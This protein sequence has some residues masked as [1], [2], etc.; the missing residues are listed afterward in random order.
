[1]GFGR[2]MP[3]DWNAIAAEADEAIRSVADIS[4]AGGYPAALLIPAN[5]P[6]AS[7]GGPPTGSD[8]YATVYCIEG[9]REIRDQ[10]GMTVLEVRRTLTISATGAVP[11]KGQSVAVGVTAE[12][13][14]A[15]DS[16]WHEIVE[17]RPTSPAGVAVLFEVD[18]AA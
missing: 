4:Q 5:G 8:S 9:V 14:E 3:E 13:A 15:G 18:L 17:V 7:P 6:P 1:L 16:T 10:A 2:L 12:E 11:T